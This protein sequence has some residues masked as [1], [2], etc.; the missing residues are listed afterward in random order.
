M[1]KSDI[2]RLADDFATHSPL[3]RVAADVA[4]SPGLADMV[5][6]EVPLI[7][8][9]SATD[10]YF[11]ELRRPEVIGPH[12]LAPRGWLPEAATVISLFL[13][14]ADAVVESNRRD[15][16]L[17]SPEWLHARIEGQAFINALCL[18]LAETLRKNGHAAIAPSLD[19]GFWSRSLPAGIDADG[20]AVPGFS[21]NWSE[22]HVAHVA[23][24]GTFGL[25]AGLITQRGMAGRIGSVVTSLRLEAD[26]RP[27]T[28]FDEYCNYC[29]ACIRRC[30]PRAISLEHRKE[31]LPCSLFLDR[32]LE[33]YHPRYGCGKCQ[34]KVPC[35]RGVPKRAG[36]R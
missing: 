25:S 31:H 7:G 3:N 1:D 15:P 34:V 21:S 27:Y 19:K 5:M 28:T 11:E 4:I 17:P 9:A 10:P 13:P 8:F 23:G 6:Y 2:Q 33:R 29:G 22:R 30:P 32:M 14:F 24:L 12:F 16:E 20:N 26:A 36:R 35:E 18:H